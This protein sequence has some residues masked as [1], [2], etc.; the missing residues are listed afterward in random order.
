MDVRALLMEELVE[1]LEEPLLKDRNDKREVD[2]FIRHLLEGIYYREVYFGRRTTTEGRGGRKY[3]QMCVGIKEC[4]E[5]KLKEMR[6]FNL[7][8]RDF[9]SS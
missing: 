1:E 9:F 7:W 5:K 6:N 4:V 8:Q 2:F 3:G